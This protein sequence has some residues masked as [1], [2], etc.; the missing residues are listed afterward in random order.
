MNSLS[1]PR[2]RDNL[3]VRAELVISGRRIVRAFYCGRCNEEWQIESARPMPVN[4]GGVTDGLSNEKRG[5]RNNYAPNCDRNVIDALD[6][7]PNKTKKQMKLKSL[8]P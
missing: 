7:R 1:C 6:R 2:C 4:G 8:I 3:F 5:H